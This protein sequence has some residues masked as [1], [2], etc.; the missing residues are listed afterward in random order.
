MARRHSYGGPADVLI[1][2]AIS[3]L[4][5]FTLGFAVAAFVFYQLGD[6]K[7]SDFH[8]RMAVGCGI[9][10][11]SVLTLVACLWDEPNEG[12]GGGE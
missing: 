12:P 10:D 1:V 5:L 8:T 4:T 2:Y 7:W 9:A 6:A 11:L 3:A